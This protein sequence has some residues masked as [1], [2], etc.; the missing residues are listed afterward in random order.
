MLPHLNTPKPN[1]RQTIPANGSGIIWRALSLI[2]TSLSK[3][4]FAKI[5][6]PTRRVVLHE[7]FD[8]RQISKSVRMLKGAL[9]ASSI[10]ECL[11]E[12]FLVRNRFRRMRLPRMP[13][14]SSLAGLRKRPMAG[15]G[16]LDRRTGFSGRKREDFGI[17]FMEGWSP[18]DFSNG[19]HLSVLCVL[20][21]QSKW[22][23]RQPS[24]S[25][26][27]SMSGRVHPP[28]FRKQARQGSRKAGRNPR[29]EKTMS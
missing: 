1:H 10:P 14:D 11:Q 22:T 25:V 3:F 16:F 4:P 18:R 12:S 8:A 26:T 21:G 17:D 20:C 23:Q 13:A 29:M 28:I 15:N 7:E 6:I 19:F 2:T 24:I 9:F 5:R 27:P